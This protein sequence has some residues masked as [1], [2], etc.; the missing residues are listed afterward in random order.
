VA[1]LTEPLPSSPDQ[2]SP[3][4]MFGPLIRISNLSRDRDAPA[5]QSQ[6]LEEKSPKFAAQQGVVSARRQAASLAWNGSMLT[7]CKPPDDEIVLQILHCC[8]GAARLDQTKPLMST[9]AAAQPSC[10]FCGMSS[11]VSLNAMA[12]PAKAG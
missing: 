5:L 12:E 2:T 10:S 7:A 1:W 4:L 9:S 8:C 6:D 3:L 11:C